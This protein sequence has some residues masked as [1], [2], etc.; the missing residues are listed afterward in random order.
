LFE[1]VNFVSL[2]YLS[3]K[4]DSSSFQLFPTYFVFDISIMLCIAGF[5]YIITNKIANN[6]FFYFFLGL[7][8]L[9][10]ITNSIMMNS[11]GIVFSFELL[12]I[13]NEGFDA[14]NLSFINWWVVAMNLVLLAATIVSQILIDKKTKS[15][16]IHI[17]K[18]SQTAFSLACFFICYLFGLSAYAVQ[19]YN[20]DDVDSQYIYSDL[21]FKNYAMRQFGTYG[22]YAKNLYNILIKRNLSTLDTAELEDKIT[23]SSTSINSDATLYDD[24]LIVVMLES[25]DWFAIDPYNTPTLWELAQNSLVFTNYYSNNKTNIS[26]DIC[27]LGYMPN[28]T[29]FRATSS[30]LL[31]VQYSLPNLFNQL[32]YTTSYFH[33]YLGYFYSRDTINSNL[34]FDNLFFLDDADIENKST[35]FGAWN[36]E[37]DYF[38]C[39]EEKI[40][41]TDTKFMSFYLTVST[42]GSYE[43]S[44][45][46]FAEY[47]TEYDYNLKNTDFL[48]WFANQGYTY[49]TDS[50]Y[51]S[52]LRQY[53]CAAMD[54]DRMIAKLINRL[55][56]ATNSDGS[57]LADTTTLVLYA[58]HNAYYHDLSYLIKGTDSN[59][60][61]QKESYRVPLMIYSNKISN[62]EFDNFTDSYDLYPTI[63]ELYGLPYNKLMTLGYNVFDI[64]EQYH[65]YYSALTGFYSST[66]YSP[67]LI[68]ITIYAE[69]VSDED[70]L[71]FKESMLEFYNR[72]VYLDLI[73]QKKL[74][75]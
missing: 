2:F 75:T 21:T 59:D 65:L 69:N 6:F 55:N 41:P 13:A 52:I 72:F 29:Q 10:N 3:G 11:S 9:L 56:T 66:C 68:D 25:F 43:V 28:D 27:L 46:N 64:E 70:L 35:T 12:Y 54:T 32:G 60:F 30:D 74:T 67:N 14:F 57:T 22:F 50:A 18:I 34:G 7:Q 4:A 20:L 61:S 47:Y 49:P 44:N 31:S 39:I 42:H 51:A 26:E 48:E 24:N 71:E 8:F 17:K 5:L 15:K 63:C 36:K 16:I 19:V 62:G 73:Y 1:L 53:K 45:D 40:A 23:A 58:D 37:V 33:S 38:D